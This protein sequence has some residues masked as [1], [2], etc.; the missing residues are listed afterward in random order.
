[1]ESP[2]NLRKGLGIAFQ[3]VVRVWKRIQN[4]PQKQHQNVIAQV[5][6]R[7]KFDPTVKV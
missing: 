4:P 1:V 2:G 5:V 3:S 7:E 6:G